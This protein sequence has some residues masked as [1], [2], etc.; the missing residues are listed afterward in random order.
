MGT[1]NRYIDELL[2][3][4]AE[5]LQGIGRN[6]KH[7]VD[8]HFKLGDSLENFVCPR[9]TET[10]NLLVITNSSVLKNVHKSSRQHLRVEPIFQDDVRKAKKLKKCVFIG[11]VIS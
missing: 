1:R 4:L 11:E 2:S 3:L 8:R 9:F 5:N 6:F 7:F 10:Q